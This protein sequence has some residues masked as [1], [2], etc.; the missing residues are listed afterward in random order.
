MMTTMM[1]VT[2]DSDFLSGPSIGPIINL[3]WI[4]SLAR[5][6]FYL[7]IQYILM[8]ALLPVN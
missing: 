3:S 8:I 6:S 1:V 4:F 7:F 5:L 2:M